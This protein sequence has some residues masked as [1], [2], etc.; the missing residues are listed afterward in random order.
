MCADG[1]AG[2]LWLLSPPPADVKDDRL[3]YVKDFILSSEF[4]SSTNKKLSLE[5]FLKVS[6]EE[7]VAIAQRTVGQRKNSLWLKGRIHRITAS[8]F[9]EVLKTIEKNRK[10]C[11]SLMKTFLEGNTVPAPSVTN[12]KKPPKPGS[13]VHALNWGNDNEGPAA[14]MFER[15]S[16]L[17]VVETGLWLHSSGK[18]GASPDGLIGS[19]AILEVK[20]PYKIRALMSRWTVRGM[21]RICPWLSLCSPQLSVAVLVQSPTVRGCPCAVPNCPPCLLCPSVCPR[22]SP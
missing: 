3:I 5:I 16:G 18:I 17:Q 20:C 4:I 11:K 15:K 12:K 6:R 8:K 10:P 14:K 21:V 2:A 7:I 19:N 1:A 9:G 22:T 13:S